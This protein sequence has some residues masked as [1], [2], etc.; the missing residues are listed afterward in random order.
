VFIKYVWL[1]KKQPYYT[2]RGRILIYTGFPSYSWH[3][4]MPLL[5]GNSRLFPNILT[6]SFQHVIWALIRPILTVSKR[7]WSATT[8]NN[9]CGK[10]N[11]V[12]N[13]PT[14]RLQTHLEAYKQSDATHS[15]VILFAIS[16]TIHKHRKLQTLV[17]HTQLA[18]FCHGLTFVHGTISEKSS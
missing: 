4:A 14:E 1:F 10:N 18:S 12:F 8:W 15:H 2:N 9:A 7:R 13:T 6:V 17:V 16:L 11:K 5:M 3:L